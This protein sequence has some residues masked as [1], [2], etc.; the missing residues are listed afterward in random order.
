MSFKF[1]LFD[2]DETLYPRESGLLKEVGRRIQS[3]LCERLGMAWDDAYALRRDYFV[4]YGTTLNGLIAEK[5]ID[6][7][8]YLAYVHDIPVERYIR[9]DAAV[10]RM[11]E[12]LP[13]RRVVYTNAT[14]EYSWRVLGVLGLKDCFERVISIEDVELRNKIFQDAYE[15]ALALLSARGPECIM[16]EDTVRNLHTA[17]ALGM[18]TILIASDGETQGPMPTDDAADFVVD[19]LLDVGNVVGSLL[20]GPAEPWSKINEY[21]K[22]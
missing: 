7:Q 20:A 10:L 19:S 2:L 18:T 15:H 12:L 17:K 9:P 14:T 1:I 22:E 3:W 11:L 21:D 6:V 16:V 5:D 4:R 13:L 8:D